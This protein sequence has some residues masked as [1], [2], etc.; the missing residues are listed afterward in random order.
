MSPWK[1]QVRGRLCAARNGHIAIYQFD[2]GVPGECLFPHLPSHCLSPTRSVLPQVSVKTNDR[3]ARIFVFRLRSMGG[4]RK[5]GKF[6]SKVMGLPSA[7]PRLPS[8][9]YSYR[10]PMSQ[11]QLW[12]HSEGAEPAG[13][14]TSLQ[15]RQAGSMCCPGLLLPHRIQCPQAAQEFQGGK[16]IVR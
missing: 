8:S 11:L 1:A 12:L 15:D 16:R 7:G 3:K 9:V 2:V 14:P 10:Q 6:N 5:G 4:E 13:D